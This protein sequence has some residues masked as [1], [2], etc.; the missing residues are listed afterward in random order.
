MC[1]ILTCVFR[2]Y[3]KIIIREHHFTNREKR[4]LFKNSVRTFFR[5]FLIY[6]YVVFLNNRLI[7][8]IKFIFFIL[9]FLFINK[10][11]QL[12]HGYFS[13]LVFCIKKMI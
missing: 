8:L 5:S 4:K 11:K 13:H 3:W 6:I 1:H 9:F 2:C 7:T 12:I 10:I